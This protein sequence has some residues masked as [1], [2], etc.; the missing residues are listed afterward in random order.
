MNQ[1]PTQ[2]MVLLSVCA[3]ILSACNTQGAVD[4]AAPQPTLGQAGANG[5]VCTAPAQITAFGTPT[6]TV[7]DGTAS[8]CTESALRTA[9]TTG[10]RIAFACGSADKTITLSRVIQ[11]VKDVDLAGAGRI[12]ISGGNTTR[13]FLGSSGATLTLRDLTIRDGFFNAATSGGERQGAGGIHTNFRGGIVASNVLFVNNKSTGDNGERGGGAVSTHES[14]RAIFYNTVFQNNAGHLGSAINNLLSNLEVVNSSVV[15]NTLDDQGFGGAIYSD[16]AG[17]TYADPTQPDK[18]AFT[19]AG[20]VRICGS[21]ISRNTGGSNGG[22]LY[23]CG[24]DK[25]DALI[26][27]SVVSKNA[28]GKTSQGSH[29]GGIAADCNGR[30]TI[31]QTTIANNSVG[32]YGAGIWQHSSGASVNDP[33]NKLTLLNSTLIDNTAT[34]NDSLGGG[35]WVEGRGEFR[36][37]TIIGNSASYGGGVNGADRISAFNTIIANNRSTNPYGISQNCSSR[38]ASGSAKLLEWPALSKPNDPNSRPCADNA[39]VADPLL[40]G[41]ASNG[42]ASPT[43][44]LAPTSAARGMGVACEA[45]DQRGVAR[46]GRCDLGSTQQP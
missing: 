27:R 40:L 26:E 25:D 10:G 31:S 46:V 19:S 2:R 43:V 17:R 29:A 39:L 44:L 4:P 1:Q 24:Y 30:M 13:V 37:V 11:Y 15:D 45:L 16:G 3:V 34:E 36:N 21:L 8:S 35:V 6:Q 9:V 42:G 23:H 32:L 41:L 7:G 28:T 20:T 12:T 22:G 14:P 18:S 38:F 33:M 5:Q